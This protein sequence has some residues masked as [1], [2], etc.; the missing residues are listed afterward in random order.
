MAIRNVSKLMFSSKSLMYRTKRSGQ[1]TLP[2]GIPLSTRAGK[3]SSPLTLTTWVCPLISVYQS[4]L[5]A[6]QYRMLSQKLSKLYPLHLQQVSTQL[7]RYL[8]NCMMV[9]LPNM[10]PYCLGEG[11]LL[12]RIW[13]IKASLISDSIILHT[14]DVRMTGR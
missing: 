3:E 1:R 13:C 8:N 2:W 4:V 5:S 7:S 12:E 14:I 11:S 6:G 10:K 9:H